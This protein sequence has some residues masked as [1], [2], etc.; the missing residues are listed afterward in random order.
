[1]AQYLRAYVNYE[2]DEWVRF[3]PMV[4]CAANNHV[5]ETTSISP[6]FANYGLNPKINFEQDIR[7]DNCEED[8]AHT[9]ADCLS[10]IHDLIKSKILFAQD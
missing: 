8:Q 5:S 1:M 2:Q 4:E 7:V 10:E 3:L 9:L 6:F